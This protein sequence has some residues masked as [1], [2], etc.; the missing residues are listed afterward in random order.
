MRSPQTIRSWLG[1]QAGLQRSRTQAALLPYLTPPRAR[2]FSAQ[3]YQLTG[4]RGMLILYAY[5]L[6]GFGCLRAVTPDFSGLAQRVR[7]RSGRAAAVAP[8]CGGPTPV[9]ARRREASGVL[10]AWLS[11]RVLLHARRHAK[12]Q[13]HC[14]AE[15]HLPLQSFLIVLLAV[16]RAG[17]TRLPERTRPGSGPSR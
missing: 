16:C 4:R 17:V 9:E 14:K 2:R 8:G 1:V 5:A 3:L 11:A 13:P 10:C 6:L 12:L 7:P 15:V